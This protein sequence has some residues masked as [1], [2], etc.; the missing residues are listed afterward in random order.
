M[1][2]FEIS[3]GKVIVDDRFDECVTEPIEVAFLD[4]TVCELVLEEYQF[5]F[6]KE[7]FH[8]AID[9]FINLDKRVLQNVSEFVYNYYQDILKYLTPDDD[10]Y[11][12]INTPNN[13][14]KFVQFGCEPTVSRRESDNLIYISLGCHCQWEQEHGLQLVF[15]N[16]S[17]INKLGSYDG[18]LTNSDA[19][20]NQELEDVI[21]KHRG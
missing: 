19:Y 9:N 4:N 14:W 16:G 12:E 2:E 8:S 15:K 13:V 6:N 20:G 21:Y 18:H 10:W 3:N 17:F 7:D 1:L 5:D 11:V